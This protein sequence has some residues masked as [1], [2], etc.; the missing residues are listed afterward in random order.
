M[1][2]A[3]TE[4]RQVIRDYFQKLRLTNQKIDG[5]KFQ[6]LSKISR[7]KADRLIVILT[8]YEKPAIEINIEKVNP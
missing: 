6:E 5:V 8:E 7:E 1:A 2:K 4:Q 3:T